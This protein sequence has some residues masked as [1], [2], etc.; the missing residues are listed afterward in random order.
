VVVD[1]NSAIKT[2]GD[3]EAV[4]GA[5]GVNS[6]AWHVC[7]TGWSAQTAAEWDDPASRAALVIAAELVRQAADL[8]GVPKTRT[9]DPRTGRGICGHVDVSRYFAASQ[10]HT[11]PG[12]G[13]PWD[14]FL[15][16]VSNGAGPTPEQIAQFLRWLEEA[17]VEHGMAANSVCAAGDRIITLDR[18]G[19]L[20]TSNGVKLRTPPKDPTWWEGY[21]AARCIVL[22]PECLTNPSAPLSGWVQDLDGGLHPFAEEGKPF[23][24]ARNAGYW[25]NGKLVPFNEA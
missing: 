19:G 9:T 18:W 23:P 17:D 1:E 22:R 14:H 7:I 12:V 21:D 20:H 10:G 4:W 2:A 8:L 13:F 11:D 15:D 16:M 25:K 6:K 3:R 5:G 24:P